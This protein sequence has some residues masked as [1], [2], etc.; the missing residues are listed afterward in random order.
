[1]KIA[2][3]FLFFS[4]MLLVAQPDLVFAQQLSVDKDFQLILQNLQDQIKILQQQ[5]EELKSQLAV[6][7]EELKVVKENIQ[8]TRTLAFGTTG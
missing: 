1:M 7:Q 6:A 3:F 8:F 2:Y 4:F 5:I